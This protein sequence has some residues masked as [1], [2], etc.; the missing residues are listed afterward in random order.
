MKDV[1]LYSLQTYY[2][3][4]DNL[5]K[6]LNITKYKKSISLRI[7]DWFATNYSKKYNISFIQEYNNYQKQFIVYFNYKKQLK[8]YSK[9]IDRSAKK[10]IKYR[11]SGAAK[12]FYNKYIYYWENKTWMYQLKDGL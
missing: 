3:K 12:N 11:G 5:D 10:K 9:K 7:I 8:A 4:D 2:S 1:L 6:L